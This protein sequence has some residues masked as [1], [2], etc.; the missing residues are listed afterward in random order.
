M[1]SFVLVQGA[2]RLPH[3]VYH[4]YRKFL[5]PKLYVRSTP[6]YLASGLVNPS[7]S[8][9][10]LRAIYFLA[11]GPYRDSVSKKTV[12]RE[13][14]YENVTGESVSDLLELVKKAVKEKDWMDVVTHG[15]HLVLR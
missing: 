7:K 5:T 1:F 9:V 13:V 3:T 14:Y 11:R 4:S 2:A 8:G 12:S 6:D 10:D 15:M